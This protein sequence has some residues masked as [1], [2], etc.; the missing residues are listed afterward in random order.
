MH[1]RGNRR[2]NNFSSIIAQH[3]GDLLSHSPALY[4]SKFHGV[5]LHYITNLALNRHYGQLKRSLPWTTLTPLSPAHPRR[6]G[7]G[8]VIT[9]D[10]CIT[11]DIAS[12]T[13]E[14][15]F[16]IT[17]NREKNSPQTWKAQTELVHTEFRSHWPD[18][19]N[20]DGIQTVPIRLKCHVHWNSD[21]FRNKTRSVSICYVGH[22]IRICNNKNPVSASNICPWSA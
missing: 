17:N 18:Q 6:L 9:N 12:C 11:C 13:A 7:G 20:K 8:A 10:W 3:C 5:Y 21:L 16:I 14:G 19:Q 22:C 2:D 15:K 4:N 1:H